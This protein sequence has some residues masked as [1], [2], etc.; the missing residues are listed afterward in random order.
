M[1]KNTESTGYDMKVVFRKILDAEG[2]IDGSV[3]RLRRSTVD[4][5]ANI[6]HNADHSLV[7]VSKRLSEHFDCE[8]MDSQQ[9][10]CDAICGAMISAQNV[11]VDDPKVVDK[12][13]SFI[14]GLGMQKELE[15]P[16]SFSA[17]RMP[18]VVIHKRVLLEMA[19]IVRML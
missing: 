5:Y 7:E 3:E 11:F 2:G 1:L 12:S 8:G 6:R 14:V 4:Q 17:H 18:Q 16:G 9:N 15:K 19:Q 10:V 13:P